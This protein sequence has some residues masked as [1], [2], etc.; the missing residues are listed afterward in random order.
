MVVSSLETMTF[1]A[2][3]STDMSTDV[4]LEAEFVGHNLGAGQDGHI[5]Q[6]GL[7]AIAEARSLDGAGLEGAADVV[8]NQGRQSLAINVLSD[9]QQRLAGL[10]DQLG[11][12]HDILLRAHLAGGQQDVRLFEHCGLI[13][14][15]G[16]RSTERYSPCRNACPR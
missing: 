5:L 1:L 3:P 2:V 15:V 16:A 4:E 12:V 11:D 8:Q 7:A 10:H 9:D 6:H 14:G 13:F